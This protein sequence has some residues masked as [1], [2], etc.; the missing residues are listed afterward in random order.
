MIL[1]ECFRSAAHHLLSHWSRSALAMLGIVIGTMSTVTLVYSV[2]LFKKE[3]IAQ[4]T[5]MGVSVMM[6]RLHEKKDQNSCSNIAK[7]TQSLRQL[8]YIKNVE[9]VIESQ[10]KH[11]TQHT[12][13]TV[14]GVQPSFTHLLQHKIT[15]GRPMSELDTGK[16][17]AW[18]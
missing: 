2:E 16:P 11:A 12:Y 10:I 6:V 8:P 18:V 7:Y 9:P 5:Q 4:Y 13:N 15:K 3:T 17:H 14:V 1:R